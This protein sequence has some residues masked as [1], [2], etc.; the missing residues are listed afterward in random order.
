[1]SFP[2]CSRLFLCH[3]TFEL[4]CN[5]DPIVPIFSYHQR[6]VVK[7]SLPDLCLVQCVGNRIELFI[8]VGDSVNS[9]PVRHKDIK[10]WIN[11]SINQRVFSCFP[12]HLNL[13]H[14]GKVLRVEDWFAIFGSITDSRVRMRKNSRLFIL[15]CVIVLISVSSILKVKT[16]RSHV[17]TN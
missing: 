2:F 10:K 9:A 6:R 8:K 7:Q 17:V 13:I 16:I 1:M 15:T 4:E 5:C 14:K 12:L 11:G 3:L